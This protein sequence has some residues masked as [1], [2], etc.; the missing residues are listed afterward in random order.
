MIFETIKAE[1]I[2]QLSYIVGDSDAGECIVIDPRRDV[3]VYVELAHQR[4]AR[5]VAILET[6]I[7]ADFVSGAL[8]LHSLTDAPIYAG[9][10]DDRDF[11]VETLDESSTLKVGDLEVHALNTPGHSPEHQCFVICGGKGAEHPWAVFTGDTLFAGSVGRPDLASGWDKEEL[12]EALYDSIHEKLLPLGD[13]LVVYP[14]HGSGSPCGGNIGDRDVSSIGYERKFGTKLQASDKNEF[15]KRVLDDLPDEPAY[16]PR[17]K[18]LN[19]EGP[20]VTG[21]MPNLNP[22][23]PDEFESL[24]DDDIV[25]LDTREVTEFSTAHIAKS[26]HI[27]ARTS[28]DPWAGRILDPERP[29]YLVCSSWE[30]TENIQRRLFRMGFDNIVGYLQGSMRS[31]IQAGMPVATMATLSVHQLHEQLIVGNLQ[32]LDVRTDNE[33]S[34]G[35]LQGAKHIFAAELSNKLDQ[36]DSSKH[37]VTYCGSDFRASLASSLLARAGFEHVS[38][39]LGS[40]AAWTGAGFPVVDRASAN[41]DDG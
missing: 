28:F 22:V 15:V 38:T 2:A 23:T 40:F 21:G 16:Y 36:L 5:I 9:P 30:E 10:S 27:A 25:I 14:G 29:T 19:A 32:V 17:M 3:D 26:I 6:H 8:E 4:G 18:R 7:H 24:C 33:W 41:N 31:W 37:V 35:H 39:L 12:A 20:A 34:G 13:E 1:G 11:D